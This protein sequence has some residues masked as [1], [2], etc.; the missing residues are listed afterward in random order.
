M[1][2]TRK[3]LLAL[4]AAGLCAVAL[5]AS[6]AGTPPP[7]SDYAWAQPGAATVTVP[8]AQPP[9]SIPIVPVVSAP[10]VSGYEWAQPGAAPPDVPFSQ[11][12]ASIPA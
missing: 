7:G 6:A 12:P 5:A 8:F 9:A 1:R 11:P 4:P 3:V 10:P 2:R